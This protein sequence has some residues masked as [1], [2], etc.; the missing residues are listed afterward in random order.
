PLTE[1]LDR[2]VVSS[3]FRIDPPDFP[4]DLSQPDAKFWLFARN[5]LAP[6]SAS[7]FESTGSNHHVAAKHGGLPNRGVPFDIT[8]PIVDRCFWKL[9]APPA[10]DGGS[11]FR[12][13]KESCA[14]FEPGW[15]EFAIAIDKLYVFEVRT[16]FNEGREAL[17]SSSCRT[18]WLVL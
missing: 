10:T 16:A 8:K 18:E 9:F 2:G 12:L 15:V 1:P 4:S 17:I 11:V 6:I 3:H 7:F 5:E 14:G 13:I